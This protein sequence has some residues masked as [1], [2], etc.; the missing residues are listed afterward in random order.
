MLT[1]A[2]RQL[3][4]ALMGLGVVE[5]ERARKLQ[6]LACE[7][8]RVPQEQLD[9]FIGTINMQLRPLSMEIRKG[10][11]EEDGRP[12]YAVVNLAENGITQLASDYAENE[13]EL[14]KKTMDLIL[15]SENG[16]ASSTAILNLA[17]QVKPKKMKKV[18]AEQLLQSLVQSKWLQEKEGEYTLSIRSILEL[19][20]Y[21]FRHY[22]DMAHKCHFC[23]SL[24]IQSQICEDC[25][26]AV[27]LHCLARYFRTQAEP[28][29]PHCKQ[30]WPHRVPAQS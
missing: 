12:H 3:L 23:H 5:A 14:F 4:Q 15:S 19:E 1:E 26:T 11:A 22:P 6:R 24:C 20:Q 18:E 13:L 27:H 21:I 29:C 17:D 30:F 7:A 10:L 9:T 8:H 16:F 2:H 28:R 25:G